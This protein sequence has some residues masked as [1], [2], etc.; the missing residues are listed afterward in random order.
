MS[1]NDAKRRDFVNQMIEILA[2]N[3]DVLSEKGYNSENKQAELKQ[4][5]EAANKEEIN[6]QEAAAAALRATA[7]AQ[8]ALNTAYSDASSMA[9]AIVGL[10]GKEN[11]LSRKIRKMRK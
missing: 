9:D 6:Q 4:K 10:L 11:E 1:L 3:K 2:Q 7:V 5:S 8:E